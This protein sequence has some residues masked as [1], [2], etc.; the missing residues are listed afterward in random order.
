[1][2]L[3]KEKEEALSTLKKIDA[4]YISS[5][6]SNIQVIDLWKGYEDYKRKKKIKLYR[7]KRK[8]R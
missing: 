1:V 2:L 6:V 3:F 7:K 8:A 4:Q 5:A